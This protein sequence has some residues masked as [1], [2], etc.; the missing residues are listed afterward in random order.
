LPNNIPA[1]CQ[2]INCDWK[3]PPGTAGTTDRFTISG[4]GWRVVAYNN[5]NSFP[6]RE[7][8]LDRYP[9]FDSIASLVYNVS[10]TARIEFVDAGNIRRRDTAHTFTSFDELT[11]FGTATDGSPALPTFT[12]RSRN[13]DYRELPAGIGFSLSGAIFY[14]FSGSTTANTEHQ[15]VN[16]ARLNRTANVYTKI[17]SSL[18][19][20]G[21]IALFAYT[22]DVNSVANGSNSYFNVEATAS[23]NTATLITN[24]NS[25]A[26]QP[27]LQ[28]R[29]VTLRLEAFDDGTYVLLRIRIT[30]KQTVTYGRSG[31][32]V[33]DLVCV[34]A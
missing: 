8:Q 33:F 3:S 21:K 1:T 24:F 20:S 23:N 26:A 34:G 30:A 17:S 32:F 15:F 12:S 31:Q 6:T 11:P 19:L 13:Y 28:T 5:M 7:R 22:N 25:A 14:S 10:T 18:V 9:D 16:I 29:E 2:M 4:N 27:I